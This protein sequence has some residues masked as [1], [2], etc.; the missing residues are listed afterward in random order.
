[1]ETLKF[2]SISELYNRLKPALDCKMQELHRRG[3]HCLKD[4][5]IWNAL[6]TQKWKNS[7]N[8]TL[9]D[10]TDDI[11]NTDPSFF[12][13]YLKKE[14]KNMPRNINLEEENIL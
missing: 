7:Q 8:L 13:D 9:H 4:I 14:I 11:L 3:L 12:V 1:M 2:S 6:K 10:M 5:D